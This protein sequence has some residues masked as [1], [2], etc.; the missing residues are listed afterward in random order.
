MPL[1]FSILLLRFQV[2]N[3][4]FWTSLGLSDDLLEFETPIKKSRQDDRLIRTVGRV[5]NKLDSLEESLAR[6]EEETRFAEDFLNSLLGDSE[7][8]SSKSNEYALEHVI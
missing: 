4:N 6:R 7:A 8:T 5:D 2:K 1:E 3:G